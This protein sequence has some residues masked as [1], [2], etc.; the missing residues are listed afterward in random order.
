MYEF[1]INKMKKRQVT[2]AAARKIILLT[3]KIK[4]Y[5]KIFHSLDRKIL[6]KLEN[7]KNLIISCDNDQVE[8][9]LKLTNLVSD[10]DLVEVTKKTS[11]IGISVR[12][13]NGARGQF[14][15]LSL[16]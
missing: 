3:Q 10:Q 8:F 7:Y 13:N 6:D 2:I 12:V 5:E 16:T 4:D 11:N 9:K 1:K 14:L 15:Y